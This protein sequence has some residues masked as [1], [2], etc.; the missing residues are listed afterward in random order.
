MIEAFPPLENANRIVRFPSASVK[1]TA[2]ANSHA[3]TEIPR[4]NG[5]YSMMSAAT[6][7]NDSKNQIA[8]AR[9][10][11]SF[12][13]IFCINPQTPHKT[14]GTSATSNQ[15]ENTLSSP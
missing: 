14:I 3:S 10:E 13:D 11:M 8:E 6:G 9:P 2:A 7:T 4:G 15:G 12:V 1:P 5:A